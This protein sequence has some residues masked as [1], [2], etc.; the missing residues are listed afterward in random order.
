MVTEEIA[1][2]GSRGRVRLIYFTSSNPSETFLLSERV[3][4]T[5]GAQI[6]SAAHQSGRREDPFLEIGLVK[7]FGL[8]SIGLDDGNFAIAG[9]EHD[10]PIGRNR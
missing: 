4:F 3:E 8:L 5:R 1:A 10:S 9:G 6:D 2:C 7:N